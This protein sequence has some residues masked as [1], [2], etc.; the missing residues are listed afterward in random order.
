MSVPRRAL[1]TRASWRIA[2]GT[3]LA[4]CAVAAVSLGRPLLGLY[5]R[6]VKTKAAAV[7]AERAVAVDP[8][9]R[10]L[11]DSMADPHADASVRAR[12]A[13]TKLGKPVVPLLIV[14]LQ[15]GDAPMRAA[16]ALVLGNIADLRALRP[17]CAVLDDP[18]ESVRYRATYALGRLKDP[19]A[20]SAL[21]S[22]LLDSSP[23][24]VNVAIRA[25]ESCRCKVRLRT[26]EP[27]YRI[28]PA[29][30]TAWREVVPGV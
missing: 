18:D 9:T 12:D 7:A 22:R 17:L 29:G 24:V 5:W 11:L 14:R 3:F 4:I 27:G 1:T 25:L 6:A 23:H 21:A 2:I 13:L 26:P 10:A 16:A 15:H 28:L 30:E 20:A 19:R 8:H